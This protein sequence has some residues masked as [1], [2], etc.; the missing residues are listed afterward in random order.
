MKSTAT[1]PKR[2]GNAVRGVIRHSEPIRRAEDRL[3]FIITAAGYKAKAREFI[4]G[5]E[6]ED[7]LEDEVGIEAQVKH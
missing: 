5:Q 1:N 7:G 6:L 2:D 4:T 3:N